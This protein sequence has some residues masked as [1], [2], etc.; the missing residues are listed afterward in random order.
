[1]GNLFERK[2]DVRNNTF[3]DWYSGNDNQHHGNAH[4]CCG[5]SYQHFAEHGYISIKKATANFSPVWL[6]F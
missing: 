2:K 1:M 6:L 3:C 4:W 5:Y